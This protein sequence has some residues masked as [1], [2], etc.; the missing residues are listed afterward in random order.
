MCWSISLS[1]HSWALALLS[2]VCL[3]FSYFDPSAGNSYVLAWHGIIMALW[4][5]AVRW[6][7]FRGGI[8]FMT[9]H[10]GII[11]VNPSN[12]EHLPLW[13]GI[14]ALGYACVEIMVWTQGHVISAAVPQ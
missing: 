4:L 7:F 11:N 3:A 13:F 12:P 5:I 9:G 6:L 8:Q 1:G 14:M 10:P 2:E